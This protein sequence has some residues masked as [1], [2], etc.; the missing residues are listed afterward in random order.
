MAGIDSGLVR[1]PYQN[2]KEDNQQLITSSVFRD[3]SGCPASECVHC[4]LSD[5][6]YADFIRKYWDCPGFY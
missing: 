3:G 5:C 2:V 1:W 6:F 4:D